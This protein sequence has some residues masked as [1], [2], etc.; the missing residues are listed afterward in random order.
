MTIGQVAKES[1][2]AASAIRYYEAT[3]ILP[4]PAR[5]SGQR[6]YDTSTLE[7]LAVVERAQACGFSLA[8]TRQLFFGFGQGVVP[9]ERWQTM[10]RRKIAELDDLSRK[11]AATRELLARP[12]TCK[13]LGECG[14][15][16]AVKKRVKTN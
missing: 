5:I 10:A 3:G 2:F 11:I 6:R 14:R 4:R 15:R 1:G 9:S 7:R 8:E 12:C 13:D 16:I